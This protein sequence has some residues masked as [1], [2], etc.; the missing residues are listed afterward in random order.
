VFERTT[1]DSN[2]EI[3]AA[4]QRKFQDL[5]DEHERFLSSSRAK[6]CLQFEAP[7]DVR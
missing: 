1:T 3:E 2:R 7:R 4:I 5:T 6:L